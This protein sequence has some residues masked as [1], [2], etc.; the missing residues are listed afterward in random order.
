MLGANVWRGVLG[1]DR[2]T[3]IEAIEFDEVAET[4]VAMVRPRRATKRRCGLCGERAPG[5]DQGEGRRRWRVLDLGTLRCFLEAD[6]PRVDCHNHG[7]TVAQVP[8]ARHGAWH[9]RAFDDQVAW[10]VTHTSK[11]AV[12]ELM[13]VAWRTVGAI[14]GRVVADARALRDPFDGLVRIGIDEISY[15]RGHKYLTV[16]VDHDTGRLVWAAV[17]RDKATLESFFDILGE[18]RSQAIRLVSADAAEWI[19]TVVAE[20]CENATLC[21]DPFHIVQWATQALDEVR[22]QLWREAKVLG[23]PSLIAR[24]KGCRYALLKN[25]EHLTARQRS[26]LARVAQV[27]KTLYRAYLLKEQLRLTFQLRG[28]EAV[29]TL[30]AWCSWARRCRIPAF[31]EL[32]HRIV[33]HRPAII[34]SLT[35]GLS[36]ALIESTNTKLRLLTRMAYG[37]RSTDNLIALCLLD[38]GGHCPSLPGRQAT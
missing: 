38:R 37:F 5:Y 19:A 27:N 12:V 24:I 35:H 34:A 3:V 2:A 23:A 8:W 6:A 21:A 33:A 16:V 20:R 32:C 18:E 17:G 22:R 29:S 1:V 26:G 14:V 15:R 10:L 25:P 11:S 28:A 7:P 9:S 30:E 36:N 31:V 13:R 4:V